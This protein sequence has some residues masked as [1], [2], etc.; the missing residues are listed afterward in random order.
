MNVTCAFRTD[1]ERDLTDPVLE[2]G[3]A[4]FVVR[5]YAGDICD[6]YGGNW[7]SPPWP[8]RVWRWFSKYPI[9]PFVAWRW[10]NTTRGGYL[11]FKLYGVD[12]EAY[13][14]WLPAADVYPG[15][16]AVCLTCRPFADLVK[17]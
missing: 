4:V 3:G 17:G 6:P 15:S 13:K 14:N 11:G 5:L 9:L 1:P 10:P 16:L 2:I 8:T 7:F 12:Q